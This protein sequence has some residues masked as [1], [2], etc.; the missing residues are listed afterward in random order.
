MDE[1]KKKNET[2]LVEAQTIRGKEAPNDSN[3]GGVSSCANQ[4]E[5]FE[6]AK[7]TYTHARMHA[8]THVRRQPKN[9]VCKISEEFTKP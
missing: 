2:V 6:R 3:I 9:L 4:F 5:S 8:R 7:Y 1:R